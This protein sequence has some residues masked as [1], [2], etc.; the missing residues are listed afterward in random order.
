MD[1]QTENRVSFQ[2]G[3]RNVRCD[4]R[5]HGLAADDVAVPSA[6]EVAVAFRVEP[7]AVVR[8][9]LPARRYDFDIQVLR[10]AVVRDL[11]QGPWAAAADKAGV[12]DP[13]V[14]VSAIDVPGGAFPAQFV[15]LFCAA[16]AAARRPSAATPVERPDQFESEAE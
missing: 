1:E 9:G 6:A 10:D 7:M 16:R 14:A 8:P 2:P 13:V 3:A 11:V 15:A 4:L 5:A 12:A